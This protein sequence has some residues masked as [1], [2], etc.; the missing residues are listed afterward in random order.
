MPDARSPQ[1]EAKVATF[2]DEL[3]DLL[4]AVFPAPSGQFAARVAEGDST[5]VLI[6]QQAPAGIE[7]C[8]TKQPLLTL[9]A[10]YRCSWDHTEEF[11]AVGK[12]EF[13]VATIKS[14]E[15]LFRY[16]FDSKCDGKVPGAH[17]NV[18][19]HRDEMVFA[20][21]TAGRRLRGRSRA[22]Q[23]DNGRV[24][25]LAS[26][27]FPVGGPRFRPALEDVIEVVVREFG[28]DTNLGWEAAIKAGRGAWRDKQLRAAVRDDP[29]IAADTLRHLG[30]TV[31]WTTDREEPVRRNERVHEL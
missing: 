26:F 4:A 10:T 27:H 5:L 3:N 19:G 14:N 7:L 30:Y 13:A 16:D 6:E 25:R 1:L 22:G 31:S 12:S 20:L 2:V 18:H 8:V 9:S 29:A 17:L 24:P 28:L 15:P 21:T 23:T 11:L